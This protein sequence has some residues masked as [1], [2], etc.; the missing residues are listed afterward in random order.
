[1]QDNYIIKMQTPASQAK[2]STWSYELL[3]TLSL[4]SRDWNSRRSAT[5]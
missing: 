5:Q 2:A 1:M 3:D 4:D